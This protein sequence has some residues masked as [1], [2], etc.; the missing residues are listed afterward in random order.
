MEQRSLT[1]SDQAD[2]EAIEAAVMETARGRW[3]L[4]EFARRNRTADTQILLAAITRLEQAVAGERAA[5]GA[6]RL[7]FDLMEMAKAIARTKDE[8][9]AIRPHGE[10]SSSIVVASEA[11]DGIVRQTEQATSTILE[12]AENVQET[13]WI[14]R[15]QGLD[16]KHCD[17]LDRRATEIYTACSFQDLTAQRMA[18]IIQTLR[19]LEGRIN[20]MIDIWSDGAAR[21][22]SP[23][24][25][26]PAP[27]LSQSDVDLVIVGGR[28][29]E[30]AELPAPSG[31][32]GWPAESWQ[33]E[34]W[35][36]E[37]W[38]ARPAIAAPIEIDAQA[39][40]LPS[41]D[42]A[43]SQ[44]EAPIADGETGPDETVTAA[45]VAAEA[46]DDDD[47][48]EGFVLSGPRA[49]VIA[50]PEPEAIRIDPALFAEIDALDTREKLRRFS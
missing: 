36:E 49:E 50:L 31:G 22:Q 4:G 45:L 37:D 46:Q 16:A 48:D 24:R 42:D 3:F 34:R 40:A 10:E 9:G 35:P 44:N 5:Q 11:L 19:Y 1:P 38:T 8:I 30:P 41:E 17:D 20:A 26:A 39:E 2:Y 23:A 12:A 14:L 25:I 29:I 28:D 18:K 7:R 32:E 47:A 13:A 21:L 15:E 27:D 33:E 6:E 43:P